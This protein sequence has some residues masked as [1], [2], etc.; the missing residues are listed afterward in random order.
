M[1]DIDTGTVMVDAAE[2]ATQAVE[3]VSAPVAS[4]SASAG[5]SRSV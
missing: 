2:A 1:S 5:L 4:G 3:P